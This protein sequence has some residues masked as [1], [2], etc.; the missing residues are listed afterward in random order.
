[1][2]SWSDGLCSAPVVQSLC[3]VSTLYALLTSS[4]S[5]SSSTMR[6]DLQLSRHVLITQLPLLSFRPILILLIGSASRSNLFHCFTQLYLRPSG[7]HPQEPFRLCS[8]AAKQLL[9]A[10]QTLSLRLGTVLSAL[11]RPSLLMALTAPVT[12]YFQHVFAIPV[13]G[14]PIPMQPFML[15]FTLSR[16]RIID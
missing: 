13:T 15:H 10:C 11:T 1:M 12:I 6:F 7:S 5:S 9:W 16:A 14:I 2:L 3:S 8:S 4:S